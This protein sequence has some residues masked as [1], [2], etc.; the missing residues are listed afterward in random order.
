MKLLHSLLLALILLIICGTAAF[1]QDFYELIPEEARA[2]GTLGIFVSSISRDKEIFEFNADKLFIPAS[3]QKVITSVAALSILSSNY[4]FRTE[5]YSGGEITGGVLFGGLYI[6]GYGDPTLT[7]DSLTDIAYHFKKLGI[8]EIRGGITVDDSYFGKSYYAS[9]WKESWRGDAFCPPI[10]A[11]SLNHNIYHITVSPSKPGRPA[12]LE[13]EPSGA[14]VNV[15][16]KTT[17]GK[18]GG[19]LTA[20]RLED[21]RTVIVQGAILAKSAP[22]KIE[23][24][25]GNPNSYMASVLKKTLETN[26]VIV[27]GFITTGK[28]PAGKKGA[29]NQGFITTGEVPK[30]AALV[31]THYSVPL[32]VIITEYNKNSVNIIGE[33][34]IK[35]LGAERSGSAGT[36]ENGAAVVED[37][38]VKKVG[39]SEGFIVA[40]GSGLSPFNQASPRIMAQ[41]LTYAYKNIG[42]EF[43]SS[44]PIAGVD[45]TLKKRFKSSE[46]EGR[47]LAKTGYLSNVRALSG[48]VFAKNGDVFAF[49]I[50]ANGLGA[51]TKDFQEEF[52]TRLIECCDGNN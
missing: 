38:L 42:L 2:N 3:N 46:V 33:N 32:G 40:D 16:N 19:K 41:V 20:K 21:G 6:K 8:R 1:P 18:K 50:L 25:V 37:F 29:S 45:G 35:T 14:N 23:I 43:L 24:P 12:R 26:G 30:W 11:V 13:L 36:W 52:L 47:V 5:F 27:R 49:S 7:T 28:V 48:Y 4:R 39:I 9:G 51:R 15:I 10:S 31:H 44:L 22:Y 34:I 17:T